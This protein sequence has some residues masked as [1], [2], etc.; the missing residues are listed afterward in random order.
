MSVYRIF[1]SK[2]ATIYSDFPMMNTGLSEILDLSKNI[3]L[4]FPSFSAVGRALIKFDPTELSSS[5]ANYIGNVPFSAFFG[6]YLADASNIPLDY[7]LQLYAVSESWDMGTGRADE[8]PNTENG[9]SWQWKD[10]NRNGWV[11][12]SSGVTGSFFQGNVG[13]GNWYVSTLTS[14]SFVERSNKDV[15][16]DV[17]SI[18]N[19]YVSGTLVNQGFII[20]NDNNEFNANY[21]YKLVY[22]SIDTNTIYPPY[23]D[24][25]WD[26]SVYNPNTSSMSAIQS[27]NIVVTLGNNK[28]EFDQDSIQRFNVNV[29]E[30]YPKRTFVTSSL[31]TVGEYL[32]TSSYWRLRDYDTDN[33]V[34]DFDVNHTKISTDQNGSFFTIF[35]NGLEPERYYKVQIRVDINGDSLILD[36]DNYFKVKR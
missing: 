8:V 20:K 31:Y 9:V 10:A 12:S 17:S 6:M 32:P 29:R 25:K 7:S 4:N 30:Q 3:S 2:D 16:I 5:V 23:L 1:P 28:G 24:L 13:G 36:N 11:T 26:D 22:F 21:S 27:Q 33:I 19:Q 34:I 14:E 35:M 15:Y 18:V